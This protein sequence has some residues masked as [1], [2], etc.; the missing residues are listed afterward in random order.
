MGS[1]RSLLDGRE[2]SSSQN[3]SQSD[4]GENPTVE[5]QESRLKKKRRLSSEKSEEFNTDLPG[6][7][8][9]RQDFNSLEAYQFYC[10]WYRKDTSL[11]LGPINLL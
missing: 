4:R 11:Q 6:R 9:R 7:N 5:V 2:K 10:F 8:L 1:I 3:S